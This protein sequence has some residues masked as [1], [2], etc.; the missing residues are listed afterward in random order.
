MKVMRFLNRYEN[1]IKTHISRELDVTYSHIVKLLAELQREGLVSFKFEGRS[2]LVTLT[3]K[4]KIL[5]QDIDK[6]MTSRNI[7]VVV[8]RGV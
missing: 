2:S 1:V 7:P 8:Q 5:A 4:G 6:V 3:P